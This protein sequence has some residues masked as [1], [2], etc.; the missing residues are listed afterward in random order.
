MRIVEAFGTAATVRV[1]DPRG[2]AGLPH[3]LLPLV[4]SRAPASTSDLNDLYAA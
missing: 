4:P 3:D 1:D 2:G